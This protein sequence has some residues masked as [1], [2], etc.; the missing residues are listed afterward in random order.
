MYSHLGHLPSAR[1]AFQRLQPQACRLSLQPARWLGLSRRA[2]QVSERQHRPMLAELAPRWA[3]ARRL[4][5][6]QPPKT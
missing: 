6:T 2:V 1:A 5:R 4:V 3:A